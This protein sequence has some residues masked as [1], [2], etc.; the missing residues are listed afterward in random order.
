[1]KIFTLLFSIIIFYGTRSYATDQVLDMLQYK[2][3]TYYIFS[4][5]LLEPTK[6]EYP[7]EQLITKLLGNPTQKAVV[8]SMIKCYRWCQ[9]GYVAQWEVRNDSLFLRKIV[10]GPPVIA[11]VN[12]GYSPDT[13]FPLEKLFP[14]QNIAN[15]VFAYWYS[16]LL[17]NID[18]NAEYPPFDHEYWKGKRLIVGVADGVVKGTYEK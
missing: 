12:G 8:D 6:N 16:G 10:Y 13:S 17:S 7:L 4:R 3:K 2:G 11:Y 15:G 1:M 18:E 14:N 5:N 9:R